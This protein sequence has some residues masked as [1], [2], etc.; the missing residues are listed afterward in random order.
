MTVKDCFQRMWNQPPS[1]FPAKMQYLM[2][3]TVAGKNKLFGMLSQSIQRKM[4]CDNMHLI[5]NMRFTEVNGFPIQLPYNPE[6]L[7][8]ELYSYSDRNKHK[9]NPWAVHFFQPDYVILKAVTSGLERT[10]RALCGCAVVF[11][12]D[13]SLYVG[14][15]E[16]I[17]KQNVYRSRFAS[18]YWQACGLN[19]IQTASW[20]DANSL[21]YAFEGLAENGVTAVCGIGHDFCESARRLWF[22]AIKKLIEEK[23]PTILVVYGGKTDSFPDLDVPVIFIEDFITKRFR[24]R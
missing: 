7:D 13:L 12:P 2:N 23:S 6:S 11:A 14:A 19:V 16:F 9:S 10:T 20:A 4:R 22:Y 3:H 18:A 21:K 17:N 8:F 24:N 15:P 1:L 5:G